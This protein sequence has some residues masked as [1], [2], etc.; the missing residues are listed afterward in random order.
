MDVTLHSIFHVLP[1]EVCG[2]LQDIPRQ[3][4]RICTSKYQQPDILASHSRIFH[5]ENRIYR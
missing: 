3:Q 1:E 4:A 2:Y 5:Q